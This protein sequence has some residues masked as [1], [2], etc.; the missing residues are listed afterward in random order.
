M[1]FGC[2]TLVLAALVDPGEKARS[3]DFALLSDS[4]WTGPEY[5]AD[6]AN[7]DRQ[8]KGKRAWL[9]RGRANLARAAELCA[10]APAANF[11]VHTGD[12]VDGCCGS[13]PRQVQQLRDGWRM[14]RGAFPKDLPFLP[15]NGNHETYD[16]DA[17]GTYAYPAYEMTIQRSAAAE[18]GRPAP[19]ERHYAYT[20]GPDLFIVYNSNVDEYEFFRQTLAAHPSARYVFAVGHIP[21]IN[22]CQGGI[23]IDSPEKGNLMEN[24]NRFL[25]LLQSRNVI[26]LCG[27][28]HRLGLVDYVTGEGRLTEL[29]GVS[30]CNNPPYRELTESPDGFP[31]G[32]DAAW[33]PGEPVSARQ[34]F[35][36][37][38]VVRFWGAVGAGFW[39]LHVTDEGV[40]ADLYAWD[41]EE[42]AK[43]LVLRGSSVACAPVS[44]KVTKPLTPGANRLDVRVAGAGLKSMTGVKWRVGLPDG[45]TASAIDEEASVLVVELPR[46]GSPTR[47]EV[48]IRLF[49]MDGTGR[50]VANEDRHF[51]QQDSGRLEAD[52]W[53]LLV[54]DFATSRGVSVLADD[55]FYA[56]PPKFYDEDELWRHG[57]G[58]LELFFDLKNRKK[59][60]LDGDVVQ[61]VA[62]RRKDD[63]SRLH[64]LILRDG[65]K[66]HVWADLQLEK[67]RLRVPWILVSPSDDRQYVP[68]AGSVIGFDAAFANEPLTGG[69]AKN[70]ADPSVWGGM[71]LSDWK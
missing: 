57:D 24:H 4:H 18:L 16:F 32:S 43:T 22:P 13:L 33:R 39:K 54:P 48:A 52:R 21:V 34:R 25:R 38:G 17:P 14:T 55:R 9:E 28:T 42:V 68:A 31:I 30:V 51:L 2:L 26:L 58:L 63:P 11:V 66:R 1:T 67:G 56:V 60:Q 41:R 50:I 46:T 10:E 20:Y 12:L 59:G 35:L 19:V 40:T 36:Q 44:V 49:A 71:R 5:Y 8:S 64:A 61:L 6:G 27:D 23:E 3:Y 53:G 47:E 37:G 62:M 29:M 45:W 15:A 69:K 70:H 65:G 7:Y